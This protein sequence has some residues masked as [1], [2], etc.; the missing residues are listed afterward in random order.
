[1]RYEKPGNVHGFVVLGKPRAAN[2]YRAIIERSF[3]MDLSGE[4]ANLFLIGTFR[5]NIFGAKWELNKENAR[6]DA[7]KYRV[8]FSK[9][10]SDWT[11]EIWDLDDP[12]IPVEFDWDRWRE[13]S[14]YSE[15]TFSGVVNKFGARNPT[16]RMKEQ[17]NDRSERT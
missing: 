17:D 15:K 14:T 6:A 10:R 8:M 5:D 13:H 3:S 7:E 9:G 4:C 1:M 16:F 11:F 12:D 2:A